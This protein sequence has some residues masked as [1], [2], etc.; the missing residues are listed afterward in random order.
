METN[1]I[2]YDPWK[3]KKS[4]ISIILSNN[5]ILILGPNKKIIKK[6]SNNLNE[7]NSKRKYI[8]FI[9]R[10]NS[11]N[12]SILSDTIG[13]SGF[14]NLYLEINLTNK[15]AHIKKLEKSEIFILVQI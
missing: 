14:N 2:I 10:I 5:K 13:N 7:N 9:I 11:N 6:L 15:K 3:D 4:L 1:F 8:L 12:I